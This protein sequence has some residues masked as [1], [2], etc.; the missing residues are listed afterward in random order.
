MLFSNQGEFTAPRS[1]IL[2]RLKFWH[3]NRGVRAYYEPSEFEKALPTFQKLPLIYANKHPDPDLV[4]KDLDAAIK[5]VDGKLAGYA[6]DVFISNT[7]SP[8]LQGDVE[9]IDQEIDQMISNGDIYVSNAFEGF[10]FNDGVIRSITGNHILLYPTNTNIPPGDQIAT[11]LNQGEEPQQAPDPQQVITMT[12]Q[13]TAT[14]PSIEFFA[15]QYEEKVELIATL[16]AETEANKVTIANQ[17]NEISTLKETISGLEETAK[18]AESQKITIEN[19][20]TEIDTLNKTVESLRSELLKVEK[21][22]FMN[23]FSVGTVKEFEGR[24]GEYDNISTRGA[25]INDMWR[26][27]AKVERP[28]SE[29]SGTQITAAN[30]S[31]DKLEYLNGVSVKY[32]PDGKPIFSEA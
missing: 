23:Q 28:P 2:D 14:D 13:K 11:F 5:A 26:S 24:L 18:L 6:T 20:S 31:G 32:G 10:L 1:L 21:T 8:K 12:D 7:G 25:L 16:K 30:Q 19:Q 9:I 27:E 4:K 15:N 29:P 3:Q 22:A 17:G